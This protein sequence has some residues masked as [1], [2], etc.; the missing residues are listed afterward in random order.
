MEKLSQ[1]GARVIEQKANVTHYDGRNLPLRNIIGSFFRKREAAAALAHWDSR[2]FA[3]EETGAKATAA[4]CRGRRRCQRVGALL[5]IARQLQMK[6]TD[7]GVDIIFFD[8][9]D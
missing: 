6:P 3:D 8:L 5:E 7:A 4:H 2:P 9:E 1:Y